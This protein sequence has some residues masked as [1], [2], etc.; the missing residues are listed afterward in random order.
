MQSNILICT[1]KIW[2]VKFVEELNDIFDQFVFYQFD[3]KKQLTS[4]TVKAL[5]PRYIFF[6]HWSYLVPKEIYSAYECIM[7]HMTDLPFGRGGSPLQNLIIRDF[8]TTKISAFR[9][10]DIVDGGPVYLK[11]A[12]SL[13]GSATNVFK[14]A[15]SIIKSMIINIINNNPTPTEQEGQVVSFKRRSHE[16]SEIKNGEITDIVKL[17]NFVRMLDAEG[18]P[19][20]FLKYGKFH[21]IFNNAQLSEDSETVTLTTKIRMIRDE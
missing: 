18:Y 12:L 15:T 5:N 13:N 9:C 1:S 10:N 17:Y 8:E 21:L 11:E 2:D 3:S 16:E 20:A 6:P 7:F 14:R 4:E 19:H